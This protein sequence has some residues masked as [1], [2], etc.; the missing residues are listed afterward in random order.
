MNPVV[1]TVG[2]SN[3]SIEQ[4]LHLVQQAGVETVV[5]CR[6]RPYS[7][8]CP[9]FGRDRLRE[10]LQSV[11]ITYHYRGKNLGGLGANERFPETV[12]EVLTMPR[13]ALL[14]SE[15]K[16]E[17][18]HRSTLLAPAFHEQGATVRHLLWSGRFLD[19]LPPAPP[20][21]PDETLF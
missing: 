4:F 21:I 15:G 17:G 12:E 16:P 9:W 10:S 18:C 7:R 6:T 14:C 3:K 8:F 19:Y 11:G 13:P 1:L 2:H 20:P 5:D